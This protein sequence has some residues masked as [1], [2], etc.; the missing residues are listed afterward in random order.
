MKAKDRGCEKKIFMK[1]FAGESLAQPSSIRHKKSIAKY[2]TRS[3]NDF[4]QEAVPSL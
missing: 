4:Q 2:F 3:K 1:L